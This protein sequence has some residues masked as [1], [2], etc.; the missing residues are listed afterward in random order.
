VA[1]AGSSA[2][3]EYLGRRDGEDE[4]RGEL[5][6]LGVAKVPVAGHEPEYS[7]PPGSPDFGQ[8]LEQ[9]IVGHPDGFALDHDV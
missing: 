8:A 4:D 2:E 6:V 9:V 5:L 7:V 1:A 3:R